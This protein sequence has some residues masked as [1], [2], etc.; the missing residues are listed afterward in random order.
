MSS[1]LHKT[2]T[3]KLPR[4]RT[5]DVLLKAS[6]EIA[7]LFGETVEKDYGFTI[8]AGRDS[9]LTRKRPATSFHPQRPSANSL[10]TPR[11]FE[12]E[13][14]YD[15]TTFHELEEVKKERSLLMNTIAQF[16]NSS[17]TA[18][19]EAQENNI[20]QLMKARLSIKLVP[21]ICALR[22]EL[23]LKK[24][25]LNELRQETKNKE[26]EFA[27]ALNTSSDCEKLMG[28]NKEYLSDYI[29]QLNMEMNSVKEDLVEVE[30]KNKLYTLLGERTRQEHLM[31]EQKVRESREMR[32]ACR[33]DVCSLSRVYHETCSLKEEA[34]KKLCRLRKM[35]RQVQ[36]DWQRKLKDR[37]KEVRGIG[38]RQV[39]EKE[40]EAKK[41]KRQHEKEQIEL[42]QRE[43][44]QEEERA[45]EERMK[46]LVPRIEALENTW[47]KLCSVSGADSVDGIIS[48]WQGVKSKGIAMKELVETKE[49]QEASAKKELQLLHEKQ[50]NLLETDNSVTEHTGSK[51]EE[52]SSKDDSA[53]MDSNCKKEDTTL[54]TKDV[55]TESKSL[56]VRT[57]QGLSLL[58]QTLTRTMNSTKLQGD[59]NSPTHKE[60]QG[61]PCAYLYDALAIR[62]NRKTV[63][64]EILRI[65]VRA[66]VDYSGRI[67]GDEKKYLPSRGRLVPQ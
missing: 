61:T 41:T 2:Q 65:I 17:G 55:S 37:R 30:A 66:V 35:N 62:S 47:N 60:E 48:Y 13:Y 67:K 22:Q 23:E 64:E 42:E 54:I 9:T 32:K 52:I 12:D 46:A 20:R 59:E 43:K 29:C 28:S 8:P 5:K 57:G 16:K 15:N 39:K 31:S 49:I 58:L 10:D 27:Q 1:T 38:R 33:D 18:G 51:G 50:L 45:M 53:E 14:L 63:S 3:F 11:N 44:T 24:Q 34:E 56:E 4:I 21:L 40:K 7:E 19:G 26:I 25:K 36:S 6:P